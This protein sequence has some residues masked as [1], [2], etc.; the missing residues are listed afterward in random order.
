MESRIYYFPHGGSGTVKGRTTDVCKFTSCV[1][2]FAFRWLISIIVFS[3]LFVNWSSGP[4]R[5]RLHKSDCVS[6]DFIDWGLSIVLKVGNS[7]FR[8]LHQRNATCTPIVIV[9]RLAFRRLLSKCS[10][11]TE[12]Y[13][14]INQRIHC[15]EKK[16]L[17]FGPTVMQ[18]VGLS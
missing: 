4:T 14:G 13:K 15:H 17:N 7:R 2:F 18:R 5:I 16:K 1:I 8:K 12:R 3:L 9:V 6:R 10:W 11:K